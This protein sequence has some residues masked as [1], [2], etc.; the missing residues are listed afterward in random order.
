MSRMTLACRESSVY[1]RGAQLN[2]PYQ[3]DTPAGTARL[4]GP[5]ASRKQNPSS[6]ELYEMSL[7]VS[8]SPLGSKTASF[9]L[10]CLQTASTTGEKKKT[11]I[12]P[13]PSCH[14]RCIIQMKSLSSTASSLYLLFIVQKSMVISRFLSDTAVKFMRGF[15]YPVCPHQL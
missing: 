11:T 15:R 14:C 2:S 1:R 3:F 7:S 5:D 9:S 6:R 8:S 12:L 13:T 4:R 10:F